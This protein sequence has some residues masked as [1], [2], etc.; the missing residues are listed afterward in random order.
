MT[1]VYA[2][3]NFTT[4]IAGSV[5]SGTAGQPVLLP[6]DRVDE[7]VAGGMVSRKAPKAPETKAAGHM[8]IVSDAVP[9]PE[10]ATALEKATTDDPET[11]RSHV[12]PAVIRERERLERLS[13][14]E[15]R[16]ADAVD[17]DDIVA[18]PDVPT[19]Q[20]GEHTDPTKD[21]EAAKGSR[22]TGRDD[23]STGSNPA[24]KPVKTGQTTAHKK[25][26]KTAAGK[27]SKTSGQDP[28]KDDPDRKEPD[29]S[30]VGDKA[31]TVKPTATDVHPSP[32]TVAQPTADGK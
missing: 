9:D 1:E 22:T 5:V 18:Q 20:V 26:R 12:D 11:G 16:G 7:F 21:G 32:G 8:R 25:P 30:T 31:P 4:L 2:T 13:R 10:D 28:E 15:Q 14:D 6:E 17:A 29:K 3:Q 24:S 19:E 23:V 27:P